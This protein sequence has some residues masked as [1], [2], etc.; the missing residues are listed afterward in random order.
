MDLDVEVVEQAHRRRLKSLDPRV[1]VADLPPGGTVLRA[2]SAVAVATVTDSDPASSAGLWSH[3]R[4]HTLAVRFADPPTAA[5]LGTLLDR[6][7]GL[8][9]ALTRRHFTPAS[10][11]VS[12]RRGTSTHPSHH[13]VRPA[14]AADIDRLVELQSE[15][16]AYEERFGTVPERRDAEAP[17]RAGIAHQ[18]A[19]QPGWTWVA[20]RDGQLVGVCAVAPPGR[21]AGR[22]P[23]G[24]R[25]CGLPQ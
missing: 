10:V 17:R 16:H 7:A 1:A 25:A 19:T 2:E 18:V 6:W 3:D 8:V 5:E 20:E 23:R 13:P 9:A 4:V 24:H 12:R 14:V 11:L 15:L 22:P 21:L